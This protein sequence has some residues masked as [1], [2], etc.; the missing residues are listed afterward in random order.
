MPLTKRRAGFG[1]RQ[2]S[3]EARRLLGGEWSLGP[4]G[5]GGGG[6]GEPK[7]PGWAVDEEVLD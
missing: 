6:E 5:V 3:V 1:L 7:G 4:G 2:A